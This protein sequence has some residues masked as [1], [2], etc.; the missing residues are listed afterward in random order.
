MISANEPFFGGAFAGAAP[1]A[2]TGAG[3]AEPVGLPA[4]VAS[5]G[6]FDE[7]AG[8][9]TWPLVDSRDGVGAGRA[10]G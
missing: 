7:A 10:A 9:T 4:L 1:L 5:L 8:F 3:R 2:A 6:R